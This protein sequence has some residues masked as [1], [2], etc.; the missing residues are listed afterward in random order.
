MSI[1]NHP[2]TELKQSNDSTQQLG[3]PT[4]FTRLPAEI[5]L[6]IYENLF[7][8][9]TVHMTQHFLGYDLNLKKSKFRW[10]HRLCCRDPQRDFM[11]HMVC[12]SDNVLKYPRLDTSILFT[13]RQAYSEG[14]VTLYSTT[15]FQFY[16]HE[17]FMSFRTLPP[18]HCLEA[19]RSLEVRWRMSYRADDTDRLFWEILLGLPNLHQVFIAFGQHVP[20]ISACLD[21]VDK[22]V[23]KQGTV[24][25]K[26]RVVVPFQYFD[27]PDNKNKDFEEKIEAAQL[28]W[29][30]RRVVSN[31][32]SKL[33]SYYVESR[34]SYMTYQ[35]H[36]EVE[37]FANAYKKS[38]ILNR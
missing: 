20:N 9:R 31:D 12:C 13:C 14:I 4:F 2:I 35:T 7:G 3:E 34:T 30:A 36:L 19:I 21:P 25:E 28:F 5:R 24:L 29:K 8:W 15:T 22:L 6:L 38:I 37:A 33:Q 1:S 23:C 10:R 11:Q 16:D 17:L 32:S 18:P 26:L 27:F